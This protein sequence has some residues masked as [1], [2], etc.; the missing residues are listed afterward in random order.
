MRT[1]GEVKSIEKKSG[2]ELLNQLGLEKILEK[3]SKANGVQWHGHVL[4]RDKNDV[5]RRVLDF[6]AVG[7]KGREHQR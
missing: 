3:L 6:E 2:Q 1:L 5:L 4:T 7:R